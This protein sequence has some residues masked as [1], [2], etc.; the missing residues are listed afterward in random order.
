VA[1]DPSYVHVWRGIISLAESL[2]RESNASDPREVI[3]SM[4]AYKTSA[5]SR[6]VKITVGAP[7]VPIKA[8][9]AHGSKGLEFDYVFIPYATDES[10]IGRNHGASFILP[11]KH[12]VGHDIRDVRRFF[13]VALTRGRKHVT[14]LTALEESDGKILSPLRFISELDA[15]HITN[16]VLPRAGVEEIHA[17]TSPT[18]ARSQALLDLAKRI[19]TEKGISVTALNHFLECPNKF[20]YQSILKIPQAPSVPAEKGNAMHEALSRVWK[21]ESKKTADI[22]LILNEV[23]SEHFNNS[24]LSTAEKEGAKKELIETVPDV[25]KALQ[26]HFTILKNSS[27][28]TETWVEANLQIP[29]HGKLDV[30]VDT[31]TEVLVYDYKTKQVMS[32]NA[33]KGLTKNSSGDEFRQLV[34]YKILISNDVRFRSRK[35]TPALVF[36]SPD[37]KG[38][39]PTVTLPIEPSDIE[40]VKADIV[41]LVDSVQ[42]GKIL[43]AKCDDINCEWCGMRKITN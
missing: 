6:L 23:I 31:G 13:Y 16:I 3:K 28:F 2:S 10:W 30:V 17:N 35:I 25:A 8:M 7:D 32:D 40:Q 38:R 43:N 19:I 29:I 42:S 34:F 14:V 24:F 18:G 37:D 36:V 1:K 9:T 12:A 15:G 5:E 41:K 4:L 21:A 11:K 22:E 20:L 39:C 27:V 26:P 33:I